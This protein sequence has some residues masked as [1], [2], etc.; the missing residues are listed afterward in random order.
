MLLSLCFF[1]IF[2]LNALRL[3]SFFG[4]E[5]SCCASWS[6]TK[7]LAISEQARMKRSFSGGRFATL[8]FLCLSCTVITSVAI[9]TRSTAQYSQ[10]VISLLRLSATQSVVVLIL[11]SV[12]WRGSFYRKII[13]DLW[14][15]WIGVRCTGK[16]R[17]EYRGNSLDT[18]PCFLRWSFGEDPVIWNDNNHIFP[19]IQSIPVFFPAINCLC[20][21][22]GFLKMR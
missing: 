2:D 21:D 1:D 6:C 15:T 19:N 11:N 13:L 16:F 20:Q 8:G 4:F 18:S 5:V 10:A 3:T 7:K 22:A 17:R 12:V 14:Q 9:L